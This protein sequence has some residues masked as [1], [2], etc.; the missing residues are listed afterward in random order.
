M[1]D[2]A[3]RTFPYMYKPIDRFIYEWKY[4]WSAKHATHVICISESTK[5]DIMRF[6]GVPE[7][8]ISVIYQPVQQLF[9]TPMDKAEAQAIV[10]KY[11]DEDFILTVGS[12][13][14]RKNLLGMLKAYC[15]QDLRPKFVVIGNGHEYRKKCE[16]YIKEKRLTDRI[17]ILDNIHDGKTLQAFYT[18]TK[19]LMYP[20]FFEGFGLPVV[21]AAL[22]HCPIITSN[23]SSLPEAAGAGAIKTAPNDIR[24]MASSLKRLLTDPQECE[25]LGNKAYEHAISH[26]TPQTLTEQLYKLYQSLL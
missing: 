11:V 16:Q 7:E 8:R 14:A 1:H 17:L 2:V 22:Q 24:T 5:R 9:Y 13:N 19:V 26:F 21:E 4:G 25:Y 20:S 3:W 23:V 15:R 12:I 6:Y 10:R 18:C